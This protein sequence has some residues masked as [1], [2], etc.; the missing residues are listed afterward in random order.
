M[1]F[2]RGTFTEIWFRLASNE[3][4]GILD[5]DYIEDYY[6]VDGQLTLVHL[7]TLSE[8]PILMSP[9]VDAVQGNILAGFKLLAGLDDGNYVLKGRVR[10]VLGNYTILT[11]YIVPDLAHTVLFSLTISRASTYS[12]VTLNGL[13]IMGGV[14]FITKIITDEDIN[15]QMIQSYEVKTLL[16]EDFDMYSN[17]HTAHTVTTNLN[18]SGVRI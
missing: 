12:A 5:T 6:G 1:I 3:A 4:L 7:E 2:N 14:T 18:I 9:T 17:I 13:T 8:Y 16:N 10:D 15:T 11:D